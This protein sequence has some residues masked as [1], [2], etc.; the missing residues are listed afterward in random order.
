MTAPDDKPNDASQGLVIEARHFLNQ[1]AKFMENSHILFTDD[2]RTDAD[3]E[4]GKEA[5]NA[6]SR[7][8]DLP[9]H[10]SDYQ[11]V[12]SGEKDRVNQAC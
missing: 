9:L 10:Q 7:N 12:T 11:G 5:V 8:W 3:L 2:I 4:D 6:W 1:L